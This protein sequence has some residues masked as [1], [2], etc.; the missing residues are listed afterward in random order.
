MKAELKRP[1]L[2]LKLAFAAIL[3]V[4]ALGG[5]ARKTP[6]GMPKLYPCS[7]TITQGD[8]PL[9]DATVTLSSD[10][11]QWAVS[12]TTDAS[13]VAKIYTHG[14]YPGAPEG[15]YVVVVQKQ[16]VEEPEAASQSA[17]VVVS[18]GTAYNC[19]ASEFGS[20]DTSSLK[21]DVKGKT[22]A[23]FD[24]GEPIHEAVKAL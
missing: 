3:V 17:S 13:G 8:A 12:G 20:K 9:A 11:L 10:S 4:T 19:V 15:S 22:T 6:D 7:V 16:I 24:V 23:T 5:C 18:G 14:T 2:F 1:S 21:I